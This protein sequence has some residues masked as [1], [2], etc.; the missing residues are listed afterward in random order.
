MTEIILPITRYGVAEAVPINK[1]LSSLQVDKTLAVLE[2]ARNFIA[3]GSSFI[4]DISILRATLAPT[5]A[6][7]NWQRN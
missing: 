2:K 6:S 4:P 3:T 1:Y 7:A 5:I